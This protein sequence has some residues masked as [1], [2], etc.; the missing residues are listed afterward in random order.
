MIDFFTDLMIV[1]G[2][3]FCILLWLVIII[4]GLIELIDNLTATKPAEPTSTE[5][6]DYS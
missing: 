2:G 1:T 5:Q 3:I 4:A 6:E